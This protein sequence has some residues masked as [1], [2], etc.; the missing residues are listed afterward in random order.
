MHGFCGIFCWFVV[1][2]LIIIVVHDKQQHP[3]FYG[4]ALSSSTTSSRHETLQAITEV[5]SRRE[6]LASITASC[7]IWS[8]VFFPKICW[9]ET[10]DNYAAVETDLS[11]LPVTTIRGTVSLPAGD[12]A[13]SITNDG[14]LYVTCRSNRPD[15]VPAAILSGTRGK[16]PPVLVSRFV[17]NSQENFPYEFELSTPKDLTVEGA[18]LVDNKYWWLQDDLI[19]SVRWDSDG[20]A[21]TRSP[22]DLVGRGITKSS[23]EED[24]GFPSVSITLSGRGAFGKFVTGG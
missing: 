11:K 4:F 12:D 19:V 14:A 22:D 17:I 20:I 7:C 18:S 9:G 13:V 2:S 5:Y 8:G 24:A 21:A 6:L 1:S 10:A 3:Y 23:K 16:P 15:N